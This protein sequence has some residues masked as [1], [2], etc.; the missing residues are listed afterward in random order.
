MTEAS[1]YW[2]ADTSK[3]PEERPIVAR[4]SPLE[5]WHRFD[6]VST[7]EFIHRILTD[8][9]FRPFSMARKVGRP[10]FDAYR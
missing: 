2:P 6:G 5:D 8:R 1:H 9:E 10:F 4:T 7:S 3:N